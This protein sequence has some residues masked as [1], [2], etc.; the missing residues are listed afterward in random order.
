MGHE[1]SM[2]FK[3]SKFMTH[4]NNVMAMKNLIHLIMEFHGA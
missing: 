4:K 1:F 2:T 3:K